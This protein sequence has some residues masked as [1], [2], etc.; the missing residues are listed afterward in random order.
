MT[1]E[2]ALL[3]QAAT[4]AR[5]GDSDRAL[6]IIAELDRSIKRGTE[7]RVWF[8]TFAAEFYLYLGENEN[9]EQS[10]A[11]AVNASGSVFSEADPPEDPRLLAYVMKGRISSEEFA[12]ITKI[13][14]SYKWFLDLG[15]LAVG[16]EMVSKRDS[17]N[18]LRVLKN[19]GEAKRERPEWAYVL[20]PLTYYLHIYPVDS[21]FR[22][23]RADAEKRA[24]QLAGSESPEVDPTPDPIKVV[25]TPSAVVDASSPEPTATP[26]VVTA[27]DPSPVPTA[28]AEVA[29][30]PVPPPTPD[31]FQTGFGEGSTIVAPN[32]TPAKAGGSQANKPNKPTRKEFTPPEDQEVM[33]AGGIPIRMGS[34]APPGRDENGL[35]RMQGRHQ[36]NPNFYRL[37]QVRSN[38]GNLQLME[39]HSFGVEPDGLL[40]VQ[41]NLFGFQARLGRVGKGVVGNKIGNGS[42]MTVF[43]SG[44]SFQN[45]ENF[46]GLWAGLL[47]EENGGPILFAT[48][49]RD[50]ERLV[51]AA[52]VNLSD[53]KYDV[54]MASKSSWHQFGLDFNASDPRGAVITLLLH[55]K[56]VARTQAASAAL[57]K[58]FTGPRFFYLGT[59]AGASRTKRHRDK[60]V[61]PVAI[62][63][64]PLLSAPDYQKVLNKLWPGPDRSVSQ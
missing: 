19:Y 23:G 12:K 22:I 16:A 60:G 15:E 24:Q 36:S 46:R 1:S 39:T 32:P 50:G 8:D 59:P 47:Q 49:L 63:P 41:N 27:P 25:P 62:L 40:P 51:A 55:G 38:V 30:A 21:R 13:R 29:T 58:D 57:P 20:Q 31:P 42:Y 10:L 52:S 56:P 9:Y 53:P 43:L 35:M 28:A 3:G 61:T 2:V 44:E 6:D 34:V 37:P 64:V 54:N 48:A 17:N 11:L 45:L 18:A 33:I 7:S 26:D 4:A 5:D 14:K